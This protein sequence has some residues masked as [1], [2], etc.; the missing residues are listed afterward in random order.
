MDSNVRKSIAQ[1]TARDLEQCAIWE[2]A[3]DEES[4]AGQDET[5]VRPRPDLLSANGRGEIVRARFVTKSLRPF[6]GFATS[7]NGRDLATTQPVIVLEDGTQ[8]GFWFGVLEPSE[9]ELKH[10]YAAL[11]MGPDDLFPVA[12]RAD[13]RIVGN[14][15]FGEIRAFCGYAHYKG[16]LVEYR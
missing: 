16:P 5:T 4:R 3:L 11:G 2:Y 1:L 12:F 7:G 6:L 14:P 10:S 9:E 8:I 15:L 13:V